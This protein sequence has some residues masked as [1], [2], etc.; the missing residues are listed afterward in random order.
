MAVTRL[1]CK[2]SCITKHY[3]HN[4]LQTWKPTVLYRNVLEGHLTNA[5]LGSCFASSL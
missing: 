4:S 2:P 5:G 3:P 1:I